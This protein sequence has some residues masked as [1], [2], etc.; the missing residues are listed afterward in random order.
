MIY[1]ITQS[2]KDKLIN[3]LEYLLIV[4]ITIISFELLLVEGKAQ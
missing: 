2:F 4:A 3:N 1:D